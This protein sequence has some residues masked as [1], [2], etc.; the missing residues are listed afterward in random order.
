MT[1][2]PLWT[3]WLWVEGEG[4]EVS[5]VW[6]ALARFHVWRNE[7]N[8]DLLVKRSRE[9]GHIIET[10]TGI[11]D[12]KNMGLPLQVRAAISAAETDFHEATEALCVT[13]GAGLRMLWGGRA[14]MWQR[15]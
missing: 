12:I 6:Q 7:K 5:P 9:S 3:R 14:W 11:I 2:V 4:A 13:M 15:M 1:L 10:F 8:V